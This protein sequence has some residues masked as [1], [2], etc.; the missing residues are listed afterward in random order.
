MRINMYICKDIKLKTNEKI[1]DKY[2]PFII[3]KT[4]KCNYKM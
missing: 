4:K 2:R 1:K 3:I